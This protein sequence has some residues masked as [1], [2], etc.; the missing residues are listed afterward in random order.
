MAEYG[1]GTD[2]TCNT[3]NFSEAEMARN[4][5]IGISG[6][7]GYRSFMRDFVPDSVGFFID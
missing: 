7:R 1:G 4:V 2:Y 5:F 3:L 6:T